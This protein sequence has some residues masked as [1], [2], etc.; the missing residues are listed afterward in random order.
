M[1]GRLLKA[2][3]QILGFE[4]LY[5]GEYVEELSQ[6]P[7]ER[8]LENNGFFRKFVDLRIRREYAEKIATKFS[9]NPDLL[10]TR[11]RQWIIRSFQGEFYY[12][13][14]AL[15]ARDRETTAIAFPVSKRLRKETESLLNMNSA[16]MYVCVVSAIGAFVK[17]L[18]LLSAT[19]A[20]T[21]GAMLILIY[22][23]FSKACS[24]AREIRNSILWIASG[25]SEMSL[26][27]EKLS[28]PTYLKELFDFGQSKVKF[29]VICSFLKN[30]QGWDEYHSRS[31]P[32]PRFL[33][34]GLSGKL[35]LAGLW[36][37]FR[38]LLYLP[39]AL[40]FGAERLEL[41]SLLP[42][43]FLKRAWL[44]SIPVR[45]I[46]ESNSAAGWDHALVYAAR[47]MKIPVM[48]V[49]YS[50]NNTLSRTENKL[51]FDMNSIEFHE[52]LSE[53]FCVW[54][55]V[56]KSSLERIG[57]DPDKI[58]VSGPQMFAPIRLENTSDHA[59]LAVVTISVIEVSPL[60]KLEL[61]KRGFGKGF[62]YS[63]YCI[64]F[65]TE[66]IETIHR[67]FDKRS[68]VL[69]KIKRNT[70]FSVYDSRW[71]KER[72]KYLE[73][74]GTCVL[75]LEPDT[76]PWSMID[77]SDI[78]VS[79]PFS[80]ISDAASAMGK[81]AAYFDPLGIFAPRFQGDFPLLSGKESLY[82]WLK[83]VSESRNNSNFRQRKPID[84]GSE[85]VAPVL[86]RLLSGAGV[87]DRING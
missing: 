76:N 82:D 7:Y 35:C 55:P 64:L 43:M 42:H 16:N 44:N 66:A 11:G 32:T 58:Y 46:M 67:C 87:E 5:R 68:F 59:S 8:F 71:R 37:L 1:W 40:F 27:P 60:N 29:S 63:E 24:Q 53:Y 56:M 50:A 20:Q 74:M 28:L 19:M 47:E 31:I 18:R 14:L 72:E 51:Q 17:R 36:D 12:A 86:D 34:P 81:P 4:V 26:D 33:S 73:K 80:S 21:V 79:I 49:F 38:L 48:M 13:L 62:Y 77:H 9:L 6:I 25:P 30:G 45:A 78:V 23:R 83:G 3:F 39:L 57:Y 15:S 85:M 69:V 65:L 84:F 10:L 70:N 2:L 22:W 52:M 41:L 54:T 61:V 75:E